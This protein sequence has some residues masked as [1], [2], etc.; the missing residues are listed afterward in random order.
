MNGHPDS[1]TPRHAAPS[2]RTTPSAEDPFAS[3]RFDFN[4][5]VPRA[6]DLGR[7]HFLAIGGAGM[8]GVARIMLAP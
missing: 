8:S 2:R 1:P 5:P 3:A 7:V 6:E 4:A